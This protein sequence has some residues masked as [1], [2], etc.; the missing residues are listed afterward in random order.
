VQAFDRGL[1]PRGLSAYCPSPMAN[2]VFTYDLRTLECTSC[3][4]PV[5]GTLAA[6]ARVTC[7]YCQAVL[8][9][10]PRIREQRPATALDEPARL[11]GLWAQVEADPGLSPLRLATPVSLEPFE[12]ALNE[13]AA[14]RAALEA[15]RR[16]WEA[17]RARVRAAASGS[18]PAELTTHLFRL[19]T[20]LGSLYG[21]E[22]EHLRARAVL[23][24]ALDLLP[25]SEERDVIR[26][27]LARAA[28]R[29]DD[30]AAFSAW[31]RDADARSPRLEVDTEH[32]STM[33]LYLLRDK[34][35]YG[36][37][38]VLLG[39]DG[40]RVPL[41]PH[42]LVRCLRAHALAGLG[43]HEDAGREI[44]LAARSL[45][46]GALRRLWATNPGPSSPDV[47]LQARVGL[48]LPSGATS[49]AATTG[50]RATGRRA[51]AFV[52]VGLLALL[53]LACGVT[54]LWLVA[55]EP[56]LLALA[57]ERTAACPRS[58]ALLGADARWS[59]GCTDGSVPGCGPTNRWTLAV[60]GS[61]GSGRLTMAASKRAGRWVLSSARVETPESSVDLL[62]CHVT[63]APRPPPEGR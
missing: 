27:H 20:R 63:A 34:R 29:L 30:L 12:G 53:V 51:R 61:G 24:T 31:M 58:R 4:A 14:R 49:S 3:G 10:S 40:S 8:A 56:T 26:C 33:A 32:R 2:T 23:E 47:E 6:G 28:L 43:R 48:G 45:G 21:E 46:L 55:A 7:Q 57:L 19:A 11:A 9:L 22:G 60:R 59:L 18:A 54:P 44:H 50:A 35:D 13:P 5:S 37:M 1:S 38:L 17:T 25:T 15:Y 36:A 52:L 62:A 41:G 42:P 39:E 16:E